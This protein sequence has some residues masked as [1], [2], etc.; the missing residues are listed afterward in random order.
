MSFKK[1]IRNFI[2]DNFL[3]G[4]DNGLSDDTSFLKQGIIDSTGVMQ[5][6]SFIQDQYLLTVDDEELTPENLDS[7]SRVSAFI[8]RKMG[9]AA[10][11]DGV[12]ESAV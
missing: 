5:L 11:G 1:E 3:F 6:V 9:K 4:E 8:E 10:P 12:S 7:I 2:V